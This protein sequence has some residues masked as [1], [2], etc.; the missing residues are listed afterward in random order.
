VFLVCVFG[1][2]LNSKILDPSY[3]FFYSDLRWPL[4]HE[5]IKTLLQESFVSYVTVGAKSKVRAQTITHGH[6]VDSI[7]LKN[8]IFE[9]LFVPKIKNCKF[10]SRFLNKILQF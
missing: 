2:V 5:E 4:G 8:K 1:Y 9:K 7:S 6:I 10:S 3:P